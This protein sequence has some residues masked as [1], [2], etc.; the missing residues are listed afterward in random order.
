MT[1]RTS[2]GT[3]AHSAVVR[4]ETCPPDEL[5]RG[6]PEAPGRQAPATSEAKT[7]QAPRKPRGGRKRTTLAKGSPEAARVSALGREAQA[8]KRKELALLSK[9]GLRDATPEAMAPYLADARAFSVS[10]RARLAK[11]VG[12]GVC[13]GSAALLVD[14]AALATAASRAAYAAGDAALGARLSAEARSNLLGAHELCAREAKARPASRPAWMD[15]LPGLGAP[16]PSPALPA[17]AVPVPAVE[18]PTSEP[19]PA[20]PSTPTVE[21][22]PTRSPYR[23]NLRGIHR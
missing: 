20:R 2:H 22:A 12:G 7:G 9:L 6:I 19:E 4:V 10:E 13:E 17:V 21:P 15:R 1:L 23:L 5:P 8:R 11:A 16:L 3:G 18:A 14:A